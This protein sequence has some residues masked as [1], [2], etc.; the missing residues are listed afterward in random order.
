M[1]G[2]PLS[3]RKQPGLCA[4]GGGARHPLYPGL[5]GRDR[6]LADDDAGARRSGNSGAPIV[7]RAVARL[8]LPGLLSGPPPGGAR[9]EPNLL[10]GSR[11][12]GSRPCG[13]RPCGSRPCGSK[14]CRTAPLSGPRGMSLTLFLALILRMTPGDP[15]VRLR[16]EPPS[17][18]PARASHVSPSTPLLR[19]PIT[20]A[21]PPKRASLSASNLE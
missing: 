7:L 10:R 6:S 5:G 9:Q 15:T 12:C 4:D 11:P 16:L 14:P 3:G 13:S 1:N 20:F 19:L 18:R 21:T 17:T 8:G 2:T